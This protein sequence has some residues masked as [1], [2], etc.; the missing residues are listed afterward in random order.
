MK[1]ILIIDDEVKIAEGLKEMLSSWGYYAECFFSG[2]KGVAFL[3]S[4]QVDLVI[5]DLRMPDI[6]GIKLLKRIKEV[7][8]GI[9]IIVLSGSLGEISVT[10]LNQL[11][12]YKLLEKPISKKDIQSAVREAL[13]IPE[14]M[15][16]SKIEKQAVESVANIAVEKESGGR[17]SKGDILVV[18]D[19]EDLAITMKNLLS[20]K[21]YNVT[22][23]S[24]GR[25]ALEKI[26]S[27][28]F[29]LILMDIHMPNMNGIEAVK[30]IKA[31]NPDSFI[32]MMTGEAGDEEVEKDIK[33]GGYAVLRKPFSP[34]NLLKSI[35][36]FQNAEE[37]IKLREEIHERM[38]NIGA[39]HRF[40]LSI[41]K[42]IKDYMMNILTVSLVA[43][44]I[45]IGISLIFFIE[46]IRTGLISYYT[47]LSSGYTDYMDKVIGYLERDERREL[48][49]K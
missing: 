21:S 31:I 16:E 8:P 26:K 11:S 30:H 12:I 24:D 48:K 18:D 41:R 45:V 15:T 29:D 2:L 32:V 17:F 47:K 33:E 7:S 38:R 46:N 5:T 37:T 36:W 39:L 6:D 19:N 27:Q 28:K 20:F 1:K 14:S 23:A 4:E 13:G 40:R 49:R 42:K 22:T 10:E 25:I 34:D 43:I 9:K 3:Q 35:S 44:S